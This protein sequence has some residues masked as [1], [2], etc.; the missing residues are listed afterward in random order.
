MLKNSLEQKLSQRFS[1]SQI[2][3]MN[4]L[5]MPA[6]AFEQYLANEIESNPALDVDYGAE[7]PADE[8]A[9][10][11]PDDAGDDENGLDDGLDSDFDDDGEDFDISD[12]MFE[13]ED[14]DYLP[15]NAADEDTGDRNAFISA[16]G[17]QDSF[18][19]HLTDQ[20][21][22]EPLSEKQ[23][24]IGRYVIGNIDADGYLRRDPQAIADDLAFTVGV[25]ASP[26]EVEG[27]LAVIRT[28]DP[29]GVGAA[30]LQECLALQLDREPDSAAVRLARRI[31]GELFDALGKKNYDRIREKTT[32]SREDLA[33]ALSEIARLNPKP[34]GSYTANPLAVQGLGVTP[35]FVLRI[36][37]NRVEV[38]LCGMENIPPLKISRQ[39]TDMMRDLSG[40]KKLT[41]SQ[42]ETAAFVRGKIDAARWFIDAVGQRRATLLRI[43]QAIARRQERFLLS[44]DVA[45]MVPLGLKDIAGD[46]GMDISTVSRVTSQ[47]YADTPYGVMSLK[48]FFSEGAVNSQGEDISTREIKQ[49]LEE[50]I[51]E[52]DKQAPLTDEQITGLLSEKGYNIA[53]RTVAKYREA[54]GYPTARLR[55]GI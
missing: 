54:L 23:M 12:Y 26:E 44:G 32:C 47:K 5:A 48:D 29:A 8:N 52:E 45:D 50:M 37:N 35:D 9:E 33:G 34:G 42:Q 2:Q 31:V 49:A 17:A 20:L 24:T 41:K 6:L 25:D 3:L 39:Y 43:M 19:E 27:V 55:R 30:S 10:T 22:M 15:S 36:E 51:R 21:Q 13:D 7:V 14:P 40:G 1:P 46:V 38:S 28:F 4:M 11:G 53:R 18:A 16:Q